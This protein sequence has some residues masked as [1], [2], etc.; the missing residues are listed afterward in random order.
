MLHLPY[1]NSIKPKINAP[2]LS[3]KSNL[4][5]FPQE[6]VLTNLAPPMLKKKKLA[7]NTGAPTL[8]RAHPFLSLL[9]LN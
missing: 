5:S 1:S 3:V 8:H 7:K 9:L 2:V 6:A 4:L